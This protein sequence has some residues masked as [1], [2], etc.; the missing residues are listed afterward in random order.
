ME[1]VKYEEVPIEQILN[2][3]V[4]KMASQP[5]LGDSDRIGLL[6]ECAIERYVHELCR[7][8]NILVD[9]RT[10]LRRFGV[11]VGLG[12][13]ELFKRQVCFDRK[14]SEVLKIGE[15]VLDLYIDLYAHFTGLLDFIIYSPNIERMFSESLNQ[16]LTQLVWSRLLS[17]KDLLDEFKKIVLEHLKLRLESCD[18][19]IPVLGGGDVICANIAKTHIVKDLSLVIKLKLG[20]GEEGIEILRSSITLD[21][22]LGLPTKVIVIESKTSESEPNLQFRFVKELKQ[23]LS[24]FDHLN[25]RVEGYLLYIYHDKNHNKVAHIKLYRVE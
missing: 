14:L 16:Q 24:I 11:V 5:P 19:I 25:S 10:T 2:L 15:I 8:C 23:R 13:Q 6:G 21:T 9:N 18:L 17:E 7:D 1:I 4:N 3:C 20:Y 12:S 22:Y